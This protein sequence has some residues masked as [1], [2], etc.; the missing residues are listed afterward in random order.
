MLHN[1]KIFFRITRI[2]GFNTIS[3]QSTN[4]ICYRIDQRT[5]GSYLNNSVKCWSCGIEKKPTETRF[6]C[7]ECQSLLDLPFKV[8]KILNFR[9]K[10]K[11]RQKQLI[12]FRTISNC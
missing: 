9:L 4:K 12:T 6:K 7:T 3:K 1:L 10:T 8:V 2:H 5:I 11:H